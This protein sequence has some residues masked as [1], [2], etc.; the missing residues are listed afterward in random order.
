MLAHGLVDHSFFLVDLSFVFYLFLGVAVWLGQDSARRA[1]TSGRVGVII[2][3]LTG[4]ILD[5]HP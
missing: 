4:W 3:V 5:N 1:V 2:L